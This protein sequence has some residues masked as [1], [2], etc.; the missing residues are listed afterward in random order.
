[1]LVPLVLQRLLLEEV[2]AFDSHPLVVEYCLARCFKKKANQIEMPQCGDIASIVANVLSI[3]RAGI[4]SYMVS[5]RMS[6]QQ[7]RDLVNA[8]RSSRVLNIISPMIHRLREMQRR[9]PKRRKLT[10]SPEGDIAVDGFEFSHEKWSHIVPGVF[11][12]CCD[13]LGLLFESKDWSFLLDAAT[14]ISVSQSDNGEF[15]FSSLIGGKKRVES[16]QLALK[17]ASDHNIIF[18]HLCS[19]VEIAFHGF[20]GGSM[21]FEELQKLTLW[22][23]IWHRG[24]LYYCGESIKKYS[25]RSRPSLNKAE[26]KLPAE[27]ARVYLLFH[28]VARKLG[29][30]RLIPVRHNRTHTMTD[31]VAEVFNFSERPDATQVRQLWASIC[32]V[33]FPKG[34]TVIIAATGDVAEMSGH[35]A[36]T[37]E[38]RY[39]SEL[40]GG[41]E[42]NYQKYHNAIGAINGTSTSSAEVN[43][44]D[45][46]MALKTIYG[47]NANYTSNLQRDMVAMASK[48]SDRHSHVGMPC[49]SGKSLAWLLPLAAA[50]MSSK[51]IGMMIVI[52]PYNFL[53]CHLE[54]S[55]RTILQDL[56]DVSITSL[57]TRECFEQS[58][59]DKLANDENLP[60][61]VFFGLD[62][63]ASLH[64]KHSAS[65]SQWAASGKI[66]RIFI[67]EVHTLYGETFRDGY[68]QFP[69]IARFG[70]PI[71]TLSGTIPCT[72]IGPL[73]SY[74]NLS[75]TKGDSDLDVIVSNDLLGSFPHGFKISCG[76]FTHVEEAAV[77][78]VKCVLSNKPEFGLHMICSGKKGQIICS[79]Y[80]PQTTKLS[81]LHLTFQRRSRQRL[82]QN[83]AMVNLISLFRQHQHW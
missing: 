30:N 19:Y 29:D 40:I 69:D 33:I 68:E 10:V 12:V 8:T 67:D 5:S 28:L 6:D 17:Q 83:G 44:R 3:L 64:K 31:A 32:N 25:Y 36:S 55:S 24:T 26:H 65:L 49:G 1:M 56:F 54:H 45:L 27:M 7:A 11:G 16:T 53:V 80:S 57:T 76:V 71:T 35:S 42:L 4:C 9:K 82:Q 74:L 62:A 47:S 14:P 43:A 73:S 50:A 34:Q 79:L 58:I 70:V 61:L 2:P 59:P 13:L 21:R 15:S 41:I 39:G 22:H 20:G 72:L 38:V 46:L 81:W 23:A 51:K 75:Q 63:F 52:L 60:D 66:H 78:R 48:I 77:K 37:H 18:D